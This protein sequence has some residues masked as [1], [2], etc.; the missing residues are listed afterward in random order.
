MSA[1]TTIPISEA[2]R[3]IFDIAKEVQKPGVYYFLTEKGRSRA[4]MMSAEE[5]ESWVETLEVMKDFPNLAK[6]IKEARAEYRKGD[7]V[8]LDELLVKE[9]YV[10][11]DKNKKKY[12]VLRNRAKK[13][14]KRTKKN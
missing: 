7:Y 8:T 13:S 12:G 3:K 11:A 4:V 2:R 6:D 10:L 1:K 5:F 9:G 14:P